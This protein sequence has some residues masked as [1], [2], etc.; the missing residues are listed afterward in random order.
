MRLSALNDLKVQRAWQDA[1][2]LSSEFDGLLV[3][4]IAAAMNAGVAHPAAK[5]S[6]AGSRSPKTKSLAFGLVVDTT[7]VEDY[8]T[9][10]NAWDADNAWAELLKVGAKI[11]AKDLDKQ[12][13]RASRHASSTGRRCAR[14]G[15]MSSSRLIMNWSRSRPPRPALRIT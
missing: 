7:G 12:G 3:P 13:R 6:V 14:T 11:A 15:R 9:A 5:D 1:A 2:R 10:W 8:R 4:L